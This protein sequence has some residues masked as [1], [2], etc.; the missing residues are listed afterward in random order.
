V[1]TGI[2]I[3]LGEVVSLKKRPAGAMLAA[4]APDVSRDAAIGDSI[5]V[6]GVCLTVVGRSGDILSF[7]LSDETLRSTNLGRM[8]PKDKVNLE[9][10]LRPEGKLGGHF[11]TGHADGTGTI[12]SKN[13]RGDMLHIV[14]NASHEITGYLVKKGSVA[15]DGISLTVVDVSPD[16]FSVVII[17]HTAG[18]TTIGSKGVGD[19][20]NLEADI[21]GKYVARF[22]AGAGQK[23][24][25]GEGR[26]EEMLVRSGYTERGI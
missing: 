9:P 18:V 6:N 24:P 23:W 13:I 20:V 14:I 25:G 2:I 26:F 8:K 3:E 21:I 7:D 22:L 5:S 16:S 15:V 1:F 12:R 4:K 17:P 11:V 10:S 19:S